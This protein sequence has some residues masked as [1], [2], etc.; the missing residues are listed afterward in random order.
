MKTLKLLLELI[1]EILHIRNAPRVKWSD[2]L[3]H[4]VIKKGK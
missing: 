3:K 2:S 1:L 4:T